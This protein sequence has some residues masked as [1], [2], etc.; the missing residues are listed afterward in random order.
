MKI[1]FD[2]KAKSNTKVKNLV[3]QFLNEVPTL[4]GK[5]DMPTIIFQDGVNNSYYI[6]CSIL[7]NIAS[8][9]FDLG[10][11]LD[12]SS[13][14]GFRANRELLLTHNTYL[15]MK[16]DAEDG[17]EFN[18]I[19]VEYNREYNK[20]KPLKVWGGQHRI[21]AISEAKDKSNRYHGFRIYFNLS[22]SQR[23]EVAL[24]SNTNMSVSDDTFDRML[25]ETMFGNGLRKWSQ[26]VGFLKTKEDFPDVRSKSEKITVK[27]ARSFIVNFYIGKQRGSQLKTED[28]DKN[29][30]EP[31][32]TETGVIIDP[33]YNEI[34]EPLK[35]K[36]LDDKLLL[37]AGKRFLALHNAQYR[38]VK[39]NPKKIKNRKAFR[40]K[41]FVESVLCGWSYVAGLLQSD[42]KRLKNHY[43]IPKTTSKIPDPLNSDEMSKFKH[44][45]DPSTYRGLG[46]RSSLKDRQRLAQVFLTKSF[47]PDCIFD[48][49]FLDKAVSI[50]VGLIYL[51]RGGRKNV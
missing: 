12:V 31:Y 37:E 10:A 16:K 9:L 51:K 35:E 40:N 3:L 20:S 48:K 41:A 2:E 28:L 5:L 43:K 27:L 34:M 19:I 36:L 17:R 21:Y 44:D 26:K 22:K 6:K 45:S 49:Q 29:V 33:K 13:P 15:K 24:I 38:A 1:I 18:D 42:P 25:E 50:A 47:E 11:K 8:S 46:T 4:E 39:D 23:T 7:A 32:L 14:E 30:Y